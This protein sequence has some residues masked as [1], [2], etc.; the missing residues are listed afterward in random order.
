LGDS[1]LIGTATLITNNLDGKYKVCS[2]TQ[3]GAGIKQ[4]VVSQEETLNNLGKNDE[5]VI[6]GGTND[7][8]VANVKVN[9]ILNLMV[10]FV[11]KYSNTNVVPVIIPHRH[12][13]WKHDKRNLYIQTYNNKLKNISNIFQHVSLVETNHDWRFF[14]RHGFH[15]N[16]SGKE[17]LAK[18]I[19]CQIELL[20]KLSS[21]DRHVLNLK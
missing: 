18:Q 7:I 9:G 20:V 19:A 14:T 15:L 6:N 13:L 3:P 12:D 2:L 16:R 21:K 1:H 11:Q 5:I 8:E 10:R 4:I 17:W